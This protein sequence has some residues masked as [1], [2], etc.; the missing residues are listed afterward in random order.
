MP[1]AHLGIAIPTNA[2]S[3]PAINALKYR[4]LDRYL[5]PAPADWITAVAE[6]A[7]A[8]QAK[9]AVQLE[10]AAA[11]V[12]A[13]QPSLSLAAYAG[14]YRDPWYGL[15]AIENVGGKLVLR[16][17]KTPALTGA[18]PHFQH[19]AFI[20]RWNARSLNADAYVT[21][22]LN[23]DGT[24]ARM[25]MAPLSMETDS[26]VDFSDLEFTPVNTAAAY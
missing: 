19:D 22:A 7:A 3:T 10:A 24:I 21:F 18:L 15:A 9:E 16:F 13:S 6:V 26:S 17:V 11:H 12:A 1:S 2:E 14:T 20:V 5:G 25:K 4:P 8:A 23:P